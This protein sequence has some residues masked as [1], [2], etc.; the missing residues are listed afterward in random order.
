MID[1]LFLQRVGGCISRCGWGTKRFIHCHWQLATIVEMVVVFLLLGCFRICQAQETEND[2][3]TLSLEDLMKV[4]VVY[5][6]SRHEQTLEEAPSSVSIVTADE[7]RRYGYRTLADILQSVPGFYITYD[8]DYRYV[9]IRGFGRPGDYNTR[10]LLL[11]DGVRVNENIYDMA[12]IGTDFPL[13]LDVID[14]VEIVR[15][16][17]SS[18]YGTNAFLGVINVVTKPYRDLRGIGITG[19]SASFSALKGQGCYG[20]R[21]PNGIEVFVSGSG[22][23][24]QGQDLYYPEYDSPITNQGVAE[25]CDGT[26]YQNYLVKSTYQGFNLL[27]GFSSREKSIPTGAFGTIFNDPRTRSIDERGFF[28]LEL[29]HTFRPNLG[30]LTRISYQHYRYDGYYVFDYAEAGSVPDIAINT[31]HSIGQWWGNECLLNWKILK[32]QRITLGTEVRNNYPVEQ[33]NYDEGSDIYYLDNQHDSFI[34]AIFAQDEFQIHRNLILNA[35]IR[36]DHYETFGGTSNP[37]LGLIYTPFRLTNLKLLYGT[38]FRA[39]NAYELY[40]N[41]GGNSQ[42]GNP[43]LEPERIQTYEAIWEQHFRKY[44]RSEVSMYYYVIKNLISLTT[45][46]A[47][48]LM[49]FRNIEE[50]EARGVEMELGFRKDSGISGRIS[51]AIQLAK[52][53]N[54]GVELTNSPRYMVKLNFT[55]PIFKEHLLLGWESEYFSSRKTIEG[56]ESKDYTISNLTLLFPNLVTGMQLSTSVYNLF[57]EQYG[58]PGSEEHLQDIIAQDGREYRVQVHIALTKK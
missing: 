8:R 31:D 17:S 46:P 53:R 52:N 44:F 39:P 26:H 41:D 36:H 19:E 37:R 45:D 50:I 55:A 48:E 23:E 51:Q 58:D 25:G 54:T 57:N 29:Q 12:P 14:R 15:G 32:K 13:D 7:I 16:P 11:V 9:G 43:D 38:A 33:E 30:L 22:Y 56:N 4:E 6:A 5:A 10:V 47:D 3:T 28:S 27:A 18:L 40:Y 20:H 21:F 42:K 34:W 49:I 24:S 35:G 2:L 1:K